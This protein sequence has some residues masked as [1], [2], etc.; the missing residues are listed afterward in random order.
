MSSSLVT[1][2]EVDEQSSSGASQSNQG[3]FKSDINL[4]QY[5]TYFFSANS[6]SVLSDNFVMNQTSDAERKNVFTVV[7]SDDADANAV[8][9]ARVSNYP[10]VDFLKIDAVISSQDR[11]DG[12]R[13]ITS[14]ADQAVLQVVAD[15]IRKSGAED[16]W[17]EFMHV[18]GQGREQKNVDEITSFLSDAF[19]NAKA[20]ERASIAG[21]FGKISTPSAV[22]FLR[23]ARRREPNRYVNSVINA[24]LDKVDKH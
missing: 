15:R 2:N 22:S 24:Y 17:D 7:I 14:E 23:M 10:A 21:V 6:T 18:L 9:V 3:I 19:A 20:S 12:L 4:T 16:A 8:P 5:G 13:K 11:E 1:K